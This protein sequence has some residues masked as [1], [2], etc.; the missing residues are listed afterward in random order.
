MVKNPKK[1]K[2]IP[3]KIQQN[4]KYKKNLKG[5]KN[6]WKKW[7]KKMKTIVKNSNHLKKSEKSL[8]LKKSNFFR[9]I[10]SV[11]KILLIS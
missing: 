5:L 6:P 3:K 1:F 4:K 9:N 8:F 10:F 11:K 7:K 2:K